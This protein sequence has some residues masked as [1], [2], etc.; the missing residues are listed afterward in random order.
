MDLGNAKCIPCQAGAPTLEG[1]ELQNYLKQVPEWEIYEGDTKIRK[2]F[3]FENFIKA[4]EFINKVAEI[5]E[6]EGHHPNLY[7][8]DYKK[9]T[10]ELWTHKI[11]GLHQNDFVLAAKIDFL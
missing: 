7:L 4:V 6:S 11:G 10:V 2:D 5:A 1:E 8:H 3:E 9:V